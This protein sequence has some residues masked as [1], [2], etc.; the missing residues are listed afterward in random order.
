MGREERL[1]VIADGFMDEC[2]CSSHSIPEKEDLFWHFFGIDAKDELDKVGKSCSTDSLDLNFTSKSSIKMVFLYDGFLNVFY[3][4]L[5]VD[6]GTDALFD[7]LTGR[8]KL[9]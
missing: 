8:I 4:M 2:I 6:C 9:L 3:K 7:A 5:F 1:E